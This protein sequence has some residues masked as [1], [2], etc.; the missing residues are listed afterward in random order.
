MRKWLRK[1]LRMEEQPVAWQ[2]R[3]SYD[4]EKRR[5]AR[6]LGQAQALAALAEARE[7]TV[8]A[9]Q[10]RGRDL[11]KT[12]HFADLMYHAMGGGR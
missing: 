4:E 8:K 10:E 7:P 11:R 2:D 6:A 3:F 1:L 5:A 9:S 12:N